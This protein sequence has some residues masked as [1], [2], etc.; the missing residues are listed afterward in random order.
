[1]VV[2][3][4][5]RWQKS[6]TTSNKTSRRNSGNNNSSNNSQM[7]SIK[8]GGKYDS[9]RAANS[10]GEE[11][12]EWAKW[13][14][15]ANPFK[16]DRAVGL[17]LVCRKKCSLVWKRLFLLVNYFYFGVFLIFPSFVP[18]IFRTEPDW[19]T[20]LTVPF[21]LP[22]LTNQTEPKRPR[23]YPLL[24]SQTFFF[25]FI[26]MYVSVRACVCMCEM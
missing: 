11:Q 16:A 1:M 3:D 8:K 9:K 15:F 2:V 18:L 4:W 26:Y 21:P 25:F 13:S 6:K 14:V 22:P 12:E 17:A 23:D 7:A 5:V 20:M 10:D 19:R 24:F